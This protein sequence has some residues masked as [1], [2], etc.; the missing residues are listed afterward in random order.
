MLY[1]LRI[2]LSLNN[3]ELPLR[4]GW[5]QKKEKKFVASFPVIDT[6]TSVSV[7][8][9]YVQVPRLITVRIRMDQLHFGE[10]D[11]DPH[12]GEKR[13]PYFHQNEK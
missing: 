11:P 13:D 8:T 4:A 6:G 9:H 2:S 3:I 1:F 12:Q 10:L 5:Y 7:L